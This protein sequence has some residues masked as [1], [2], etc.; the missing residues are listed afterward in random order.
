MLGL[1]E[2]S[3]ERH[4]HQDDGGVVANNAEG[5]FIPGE[6]TVEGRPMVTG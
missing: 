5:Q 1:G 6:I 2:R 4:N 3:A